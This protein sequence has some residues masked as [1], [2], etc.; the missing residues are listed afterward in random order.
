MIALAKSPILL[1]MGGKVKAFSQFRF[2]SFS[3]YLND[4]SEGG[5]WKWGVQA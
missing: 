1:L 4:P 3:P 2:S 5:W